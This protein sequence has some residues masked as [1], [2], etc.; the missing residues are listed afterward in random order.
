M[1]TIYINYHVNLIFY[2]NFK[3]IGEKFAVL[4]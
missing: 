1:K 2:C 3:L 4:I